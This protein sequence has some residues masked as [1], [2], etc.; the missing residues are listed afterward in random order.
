MSNQTGTLYIVATPIGNLEDLSPRAVQIF[1]KVKYVAVEDTRH[2]RKLF[3]HYCLSP[4]VLSIHKF[5]EH[6][7]EIKIVKFLEAGDDVALI[8]DAGTP[9]ICDPGLG[10]VKLCH[11]KGIKVIPIPGPSALICALSIAGL[12]AEKFLFEGFLSDKK[13]KRINQLRNL[14]YESRTM[15]F[16]EAPHRI[17]DFL[18]DLINVFGTERT[19]VVAREITKKFEVTK[20]AAAQK[21][22]EW[23]LQDA[24]QQ[25]GEFVVIVKGNLE[26][27]NQFSFKTG[28]ILKLL[29]EELPL[30]KAA[31]ITSKITGNSKNEIYQLGLKLQNKK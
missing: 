2:S 23:I 18:K 6:K 31:S 25:K 1:K 14:E 5:N 7:S 19:V 10:L 26:R 17:I 28:L 12:E 20:S 16:F 24:N 30:K 4:R 13:T 27:E 8:S 11:I 22:L 21:I 3:Q 29:L 15:V 9:L